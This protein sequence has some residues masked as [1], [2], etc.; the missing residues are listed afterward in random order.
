MNIDYVKNKTIKH[1]TTILTYPKFLSNIWISGVI[2]QHNILL[3]PKTLS[4]PQMIKYCRPLHADG[5]IHDNH[6]SRVEHIQHGSLAKIQLLEGYLVQLGSLDL[7]ACL[8]EIGQGGLACRAR[9][10][11]H[12]HYRSGCRH[13]D[14]VV[15][16]CDVRWMFLFKS[17]KRLIRLGACRIAK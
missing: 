4:H 12:T 2:V 17:R 5:D 8:S 13:V 7:L 6:L 16:C 9:L 14:D 11:E 1:Q 10:A 3:L 15:W